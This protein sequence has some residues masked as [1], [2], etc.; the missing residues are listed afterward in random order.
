MTSPTG[1]QYVN[2]PNEI[3][4]VAEKTFAYE[5]SF[6]LSS[7]EKLEGFQLRYEC[8]GE[9]N[10]EKD[11][12]IYVCH[13]LTG[14]HHVAGVYSEKDEKPGWWNHVV[15]PG[16]PIDTN[17][18]FVLS[19]NCLGGCRG[20]TGP[21]SKIPNETDRTFGASFPDLSI[22]DMIRAQRQLIDH[23]GINKLHAVV[24]GSMGGMQ[25]LQWIVEYSGF[26]KNAVIIAA[27][28]QHS[29]Q[30]IAFNEAGRNAIRGDLEWK[31]G[32]YSKEEGPAQGLSVAR[33][34]AHITYLSDV[35]MEEKFGGDHRLDSSNDFEFS[36][37]GYLSYQGKK[38]VDRFDANSYLKLTEALD[39]FDLVGKSGLAEAVKHVDART[40][41]IAFSSDWLYTPK[42]NKLIADALLSAG[43]NASYLEIEDSHG[44]D[45]FLINSKP[46]LKA[47]DVFLKPDQ[48]ESQQILEEDGFRK[49][50]N[51]YEVKKEADFR[52][53]DRWVKPK[54]KVLDLGCGRGLLLEHLR[55]SKDVFGL[56]IDRELHKSISCVARKVPI[57][58]EDIFQGLSKFKDNSFDWVIFSRMIESLPEPGSILKE[59]LRVGK[60]VAVSFVNHG[61]WRNRWNFLVEGKRVCNEVYP[62]QWESSHLSNHFSINEFREFCLRLQADGMKVSLGR[63]VYYRGDWLRRCSL[64]ANLRAGLAIIEIQK[65]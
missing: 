47:L 19:S 6:L 35:G 3:G 21:A 48:N 28:A 24:G 22:Q 50:K 42:Q 9:L 7:G 43:K 27:T 37:Q 20:S 63:K 13:A 62:H 15:G 65:D 55:E 36:V 60:R 31:G 2:H 10:K 4:M 46:F 26:V 59:S 1:S 23:L 53:I 17:R 58:Q 29:V 64:F 25:A 56:G 51:R 57:Y 41:I 12:A 38:F 52:A 14:D 44:H 30:T 32:N 8:Y 54:E 45:S 49:V 18:F 39:R 40:L 11:N 34:M 33:M 16:K 61:Y 5:E